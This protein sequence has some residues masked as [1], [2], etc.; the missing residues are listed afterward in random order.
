MS[1]FRFR[2]AGLPAGESEQRDAPAK[3]DKDSAAGRRCLELPMDG[4]LP[5]REVGG[6][7]PER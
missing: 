1:S 6:S 4:P 5:Q 2:P 3:C 7:R